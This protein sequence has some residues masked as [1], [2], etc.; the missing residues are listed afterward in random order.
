MANFLV[1][2]QE[3]GAI[4]GSGRLGGAGLHGLWSV[5]CSLHH[6]AVMHSPSKLSMAVLGLAIIGGWAPVEHAAEADRGQ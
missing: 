2:R 4:L 6:T 5:A 3:L 1:P